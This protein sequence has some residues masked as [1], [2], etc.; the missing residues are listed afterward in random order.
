MTKERQRLLK[1]R[2]MYKQKEKAAKTKSVV[3]LAAPILEEQPRTE[4]IPATVNGAVQAEDDTATKADPGREE[5]PA[6][7]GADALDEVQQSSEPNGHSDDATPVDDAAT[8]DESP[9]SETSTAIHVGKAEVSTPKADEVA[10]EHQAAAT[11]IENAVQTDVQGSCDDA[12]NGSETVLEDSQKAE[13]PSTEGH[14]TL[15]DPYSPT[16]VIESGQTS[17]R[18]TSVS[19]SVPASAAEKSP[20]IADSSE[21]EATVVLEPECEPESSPPVEI[22][23][24]TLVSPA[25]E[26]AFVA[27]SSRVETA[28]PAISREVSYNEARTGTPSTQISSDLPTG[29]A[30]PP[31]DLTT[32]ASSIEIDDDLI[33]EL[34]AAKVQ[35]AKPVSVSSKSPIAS[36][37][38][39]RSNIGAFR[40]FSAPQKT[41]PDT[42]GNDKS[43]VAAVSP[44]GRLRSASSNSGSPTITRSAGESTPVV[45]KRVEG[46]IAAKIADLQRS[47]SKGSPTDPNP[48]VPSGK[49]AAHKSIP[50]HVNTAS[51][52]SYTPPKRMS[53]LFG[54]KRV[55]TPP[56][57]EPQQHT[58]SPPRSVPTNFYNQSVVPRTPGESSAAATPKSES[59]SVRTTIIHKDK[60]PMADPVVTVESRE[61]P[62][63]RQSEFHSSPLLPTHHQRANSATSFRR[64]SFHPVRSASVSSFRSTP[65]S[66]NLEQGQRS[67][68]FSFARRSIDGGWRSFATRR[69][70]E[71]RPSSSAPPPA[72]SSAMSSPL[73][74]RNFST[75][76]LDTAA[77]GDSYGGV[78]G[79]GLTGVGEKKPSRTSRLLKRMSSSISSITHGSRMQ[80]QTLSERAAHE[81]EAERPRVQRPKAVAVG[82]LNVQFPDTLVCASR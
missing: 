59:M 15:Q 1:F 36:F 24:A 48:Y 9:A 70:S 44:P 28:T 61:S 46:G 67:D 7:S 54:S 41:V 16:S 19:D 51:N 35:E 72:P 17:T 47:F 75:T 5:E 40:T 78:R 57:A 39:R 76:S 77:S 58:P 56:P 74:P 25:T 81:E 49:G 53:S 38:Q 27:E 26:P 52:S 8:H 60:A 12:T 32:S 62:R 33:D 23:Q 11:E 69:K 22:P 73:I 71:S 6:K 2:E 4:E 79:L 29:A 21:E 66:P 3:V 50:L 31:L 20:K 13:T 45:K 34:Q 18:P 10:E 82:D 65:N 63:L 37:F 64:A 55:V 43:P 14:A 42:N 30:A 68:A 80:L